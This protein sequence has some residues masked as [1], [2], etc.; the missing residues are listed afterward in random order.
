MGLYANDSMVPMLSWRQH[1]DIPL[2]SSMF[3]VAQLRLLV[4]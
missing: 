4:T 2:A 1:C 3:W